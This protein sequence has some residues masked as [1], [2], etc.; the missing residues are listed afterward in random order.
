MKVVGIRLLLAAAILFTL[1]LLVINVAG[2]LPFMAAHKADISGAPYMDFFM[3]SLLNPVESSIVLVE[4]KNPLF[5]IGSVGAVLL[6]LYAVFFAKDRKGEYELADRY[7]VYGKARWARKNEIFVTSE[8][9]CVPAKQLI[10]DLEASM[11][12]SGGEK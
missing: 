12:E 6:A 2:L 11:M 10:H 1:E 4:G 9:V 3:D 5:F 7:G 8:T